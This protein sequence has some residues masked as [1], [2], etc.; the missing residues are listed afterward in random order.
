MVAHTYQPAA[1]MP[2]PGNEFTNRRGGGKEVIFWDLAI[3]H[4]TSS[5]KEGLCFWLQLINVERVDTKWVLLLKEERMIA[6]N[7]SHKN[8]FMAFFQLKTI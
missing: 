7:V 8:F 6:T 3:F 1:D 2:S 5:S 4:V